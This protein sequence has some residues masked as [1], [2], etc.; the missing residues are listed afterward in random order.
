MKYNEYQEAPVCVSDTRS[1]G[2]DRKYTD[3]LHDQAVAD[4]YR[5]YGMR[6][7]SSDFIDRKRPL[8]VDSISMDRD[9]GIDYV[10]MT[11]PHTNQQEN[12]FVQE[13][14]R[15]R[16]YDC[17]TDIT[18]R[19]ERNN[20]H[21]I[22]IGQQKSEFY[23]L[24][25][26]ALNVYPYYSRNFRFPSH[27]VIMYGFSDGYHIYKWAVADIVWLYDLIAKGRVIIDRSVRRTYFDADGRMHA[28]VEHNSDNS[29]DF[30]AFDVPGLMNIASEYSG[31]HIIQRGFDR[32]Y[33]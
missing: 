14:F 10:A 7:C 29:S 31:I 9:L 17:H 18:V 1:Y 27:L 3:K 13:R 32:T 33:A 28:P 6:L 23:K 22:S 20:A 8:G 15:Q 26:T 11:N 5:L 12:Y 24:Q 2:N 16:K 19:L 30:V 25:N 4:I 21:S